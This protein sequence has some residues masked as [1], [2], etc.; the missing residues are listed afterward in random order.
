[1]YPFY[2]NEQERPLYGVLH[3][4]EGDDYRE[5]GIIL[6]YP[7]GQEYER[8]HRAMR[9]IAN[10]LSQAGYDVLRFDY[11]AT[12]DSYGDCTEG[13]LTQWESDICKAVEELQESSGIE[14]VN[15]VGL[16]LGATLALRVADK[17]PHL[18]RCVAWDPIVKGDEFFTEITQY[19]EPQYLKALQNGNNDTFYLKGYE[20]PA[21]LRDEIRDI[22][23][24]EECKTK[25]VLDSDLLFIGSA[26]DN[27]SCKEAASAYEAMG[28]N[29]S[30]RLV[31]SECDWYAAVAD[32]GILLP[33]PVIQEI[34]R[35]FV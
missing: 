1:M 26:A 16:R 11:Y 21:K 7:L 23:L 31:E 35:Y 20:V 13:S 33:Q 3:P 18:K 22:N 19:V 12:G 9:N 4:S 5:E 32:G 2:F 25:A 28:T 29:A 10:N 8:S 6:C 27:V 14:T 34:Y 30:Y 24:L 15:L 17:I